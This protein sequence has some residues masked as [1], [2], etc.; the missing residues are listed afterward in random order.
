MGL[1]DLIFNRQRVRI[2]TTSP[3]PNYPLPALVEFD[4]SVSES[5]NDESEIT[6]HPI[7]MGSD[8]TDHFRK[9]PI[10]LTLELK[11]T[12]TPVVF[13]ASALSN[14][15]VLTDVVRPCFDRVEAAYAKLREFQESGVL[16]DVVTSLRSYSNMAILSIAVPRDKD[17]GNELAVTLTLREV[18][19][20]NSLSVDVPIPEEVANNAPANAGQQSTSTAGS[21][22]S[23]TSESVLSSLAGLLGG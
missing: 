12:N 13:L 1:T 3:L 17:I 16:V 4:A 19:I 15:P 14:S 18:K 10:T 23:G 8:V 20:A 21:A 11:V 9:L 6:D 7:E 22:Q 2:G 5:H